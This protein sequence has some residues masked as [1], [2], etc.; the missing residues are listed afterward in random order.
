MEPRQDL[1]SLEERVKKARLAPPRPARISDHATMA[2]VEL[3]RN[4]RRGKDG[5]EPP[6]AGFAV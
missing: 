6:T 3:V 5:M 4:A 2:S 1:P